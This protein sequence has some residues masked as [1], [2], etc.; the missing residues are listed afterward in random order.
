[1]I[2]GVSKLGDNVWELAEWATAAVGAP[3]AL[4]CILIPLRRIDGAAAGLS[5]TG[6]LFE[7]YGGW[8]AIFICNL[9]WGNILYCLAIYGLVKRLQTVAI[10]I[11]HR[12]PLQDDIAK[13]LIKFG[14]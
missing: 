4:L 3:L 11:N 14:H 12:I 13:L 5:T 9:D 6:I 8:N 2:I 10:L 7:L 1:M